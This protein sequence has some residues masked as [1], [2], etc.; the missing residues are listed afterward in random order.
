VT[1]AVEISGRLL[2]PNVTLPHFEF[3]DHVSMVEGAVT[4][5]FKLRLSPP[6]LSVAVQAVSI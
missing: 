5:C 4:V 3:L 2:N 6:L 1:G